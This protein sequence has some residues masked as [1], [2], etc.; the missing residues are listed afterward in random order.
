[1]CVKCAVRDSHP[2][3][4]LQLYLHTPHSQGETPSML[5]ASILLLLCHNALAAQIEEDQHKQAENLDKVLDD[6]I[7]N[8]ELDGDNLI[9]FPAWSDDSQ[10]DNEDLH[11]Q[12][13]TEEVK[14]NI[15]EGINKISDLVKNYLTQHFNK[16]K[17]NNKN[18]WTFWKDFFPS[19]QKNSWNNNF[20]LHSQLHSQPLGGPWSSLREIFTP[21]TPPPPHNWWT[22]MFSSN[23]RLDSPASPDSMITV[24]HKMTVDNKTREGVAKVPSS[25]L[26]PIMRRVWDSLSSDSHMALGFGAFLPFLGLLLPLVI[27]AAIVPIIL[28]VMVSMFGIMSGALVLLPLLLTGLLG[29]GALPVDRMIEELF[30]SEF[31]GENFLDNYLE[32]L[33]QKH[34]IEDSTDKVVDGIDEIPRFISF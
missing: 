17:E 13:E 19:H 10:S 29:Q 8:T 15:D 9:D 20:W 30:L 27:F 6:T 5:R 31:D 28:L 11:D 32:D 24:Y 26:M 16:R 21:T 34:Q 4:Q 18:R 1:M 23:S 33:T 22:E 25:Q 3:D 7:Q 12:E 2:A 14:D